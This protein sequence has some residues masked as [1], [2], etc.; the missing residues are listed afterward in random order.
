VGT[1]RDTDTGPRFTEEI[2]GPVEA[3][4][5]RGFALTVVEGGAPATWRSSPSA[6]D[7]CSIGSHPLN[8]L[9]IDEPTVSRFHCELR[10]GARGVT[11]RDLD[12]R[13]GLILDGV[14][15]TEA[16][17]KNG[18][19]L[20]MGRPVVRFELA[21]ESHR[22]RLSERT[23][24]GGLVGVSVPMRATFA[25]LER[26]AATD[27]TILLEGETGTGKGA[28]AEA[29][30]IESARRDKPFLVVD[31][32][33]IPA[34]L[35]ESELFG[36]EKGAFTGADARRL[37][38]FEEAGGGT[39]FLDEIGELPPELQPK[40]L[41]VL[42]NREVRRLGQNSYRPVDV[43][44]IAATNRDLRAEVNAGRFRSDLYYRL[45]VLKIPIPP[46]RQRLDDLPAL[47]R[48]VLA[49]LDATPEQIAELTR[50]EVLAQ[51]GHGAWSGNVR[52]LRNYLERCLVLQGPAPLDQHHAHH[53]GHAVDASLPYAEA[54]QRA[55][56][57]FE[58]SY[59]T[60]LLARHKEKVAPAAR[61]A[62]IARVHL[63][64][65]MRRHGVTRT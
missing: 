43:R 3:G 23:R 4:A 32:G 35:L 17:L 60:A 50:A 21:Q 8:D 26:A 19:L 63:Y 38:A 42:E 55:L 29:I 14:T 46:I 22:L 33:A 7:R 59:V 34:P 53:P 12:S 49:N 1:I 2:Q 52:E 56:E 44:V 37:G 65:L 5:V 15:V 47:V 16:Q 13:N 24:F 30:H 58:R 45:A 11:V 27:A 9:V 6:I 41:R 28:S 36:H 62:G 61:A 54:R 18:S 64:R 25:L 20:R 39:I 57:T 51:M 40:L 10:S 48:E 31:C